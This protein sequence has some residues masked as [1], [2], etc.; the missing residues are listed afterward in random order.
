MSTKHVRT[1]GDI[2]RFNCALKVESC[3]LMSRAFVWCGEGCGD[4]P[5]KL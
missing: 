2:V 1:T 3:H 5:K 4:A